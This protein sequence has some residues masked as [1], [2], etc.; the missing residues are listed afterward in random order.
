MRWNLKEFPCRTGGSN[1]R[2]TG[3]KSDALPI[4]LSRHLLWSWEIL[5]CIYYNFA[6]CSTC[7][8]NAFFFAMAGIQS[9]WFYKK[10]CYKTLLLFYIDIFQ[11]NF[12][13]WHI[14]IPFCF[15]QYKQ[16]FSLWLMFN[17]Y[18]FIRN[19]IFFISDA[20]LKVR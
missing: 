15:L 8:A 2:S 12:K 9:V 11:F 18:G 1:L 20:L 4:E 14:I 6:F 7:S 5:E 16:G 17:Q 10:L 3:P 13:H 19:W